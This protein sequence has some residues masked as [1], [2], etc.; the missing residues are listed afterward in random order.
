M[1]LMGAHRQHH[2]VLVRLL[3]L[4]WRLEPAPASTW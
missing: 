1:G 3:L 2:L 4:W